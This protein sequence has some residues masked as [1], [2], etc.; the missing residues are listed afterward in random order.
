MCEEYFLWNTTI[1]VRMYWGRGQTTSIPNDS[2]QE[3]VSRWLTKW[4]HT[5][6]VSVFWGFVKCSSFYIFINMWP[7]FEKRYITLSCCLNVITAAIKYCYWQ[8]KLDVRNFF[9][10]I[11]IECFFLL[12]WR[13][14]T[15]QKVSERERE[16]VSLKT[17]KNDKIA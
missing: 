5:E 14:M 17:L 6:D 2:C 15:R 16:T 9:C 11:L 3:D 7:N 10:N 13:P 8:R 1:T 4:H 12:L